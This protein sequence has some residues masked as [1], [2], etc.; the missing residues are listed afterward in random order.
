MY[1]QYKIKRNKIYK[2]CE[3]YLFSPKQNE[4]LHS[5]RERSNDAQLPNWLLVMSTFYF[6]YFEKQQRYLFDIP[7]YFDLYFSSRRKNSSCVLSY[8]DGDE[9]S[10]W[11]KWQRFISTERVVSFLLG[12]PCG[13]NG[14]GEN[15]WCL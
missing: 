8:L 12:F 3:W 15:H 6:R 9:I 7:F 13:F 5:F 1:L 11:I 4:S 14:G 10:R 2:N